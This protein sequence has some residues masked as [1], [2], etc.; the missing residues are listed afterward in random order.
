MVD[1]AKARL[2]GGKGRRLAI[3]P[4][5]FA[6]DSDYKLAPEWYLRSLQRQ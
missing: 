6:E 2:R 1:E 5:I 3:V 4:N